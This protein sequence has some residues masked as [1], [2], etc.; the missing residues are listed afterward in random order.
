MGL[1]AAVVVVAIVVVVLV[2]THLTPKPSGLASEFPSQIVQAAATAAQQA[3]GFEMSAT[4]NFGSGVTAFDFKV[5]GNDIDGSL[6][7][8]GSSIALDIIGGN[9][10]FEAPAAFWTAEGM[11]TDIAAQLAGQWVEA[12]AGSSTASDFS[13]VSSFTDISSALKQHGTLAAG[14]TATVDGQAVVIVKDTSNGGSLAV[15]TSGTAYPV[16]LSQTTGST[17][18]VITFSDWDAVS[19]FTPPPNAVTVPSS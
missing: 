16:R 3:S 13:G 5:R 15:A 6:T 8:D 4:G 2:L 11:S 9:V 12:P 19:A 17:T 7:L 10:Y 14:G 18:G 1:V